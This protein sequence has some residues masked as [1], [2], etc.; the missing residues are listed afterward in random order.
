MTKLLPFV[1]LAVISLAA[2]KP[3]ADKKTDK[4]LLQGSWI[5]TNA[6][7]NGETVKQPADKKTVITIRGNSF[8]SSEH[9]DDEGTVKIEEDK[10][11][12]TLDVTM[13]HNGEQSTQL[14]IYEFK[15]DKLTICIAKKEKAYPK[16]L[17]SQEGNMLLTLRRET[18]E[19]ANKRIPEAD[20]KAD[21]IRTKELA[22]ACDT[23][24]INNKMW[25]M[26]LDDLANKQPNGGPAM[27]D[28]NRLKSKV[29]GKFMYD[30]VGPNNNGRL[31]DIW[32]EGPNG[33]IG[34]WMKELKSPEKK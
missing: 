4:D 2:D 30:P 12:K 15:G 24:R 29:G 13:T 23:Y 26:S 32:V 25:P 1:I 5:V 31:P 33:P 19:E 28:G 7:L 6:E 3:A 27:I 9:P 22:Q 20:Q 10:K 21:L 18:I 8:T 14:A 34:N 16:E 17:K 11:P